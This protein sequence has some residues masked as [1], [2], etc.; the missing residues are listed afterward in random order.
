M[1]YI[2][3]IFTLLLV[4]GCAKTPDIFDK[5]WEKVQIKMKS[6]DKIEQSDREIMKEATEEEWKEVD[7]QS[8]TIIIPLKKPI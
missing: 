2:T 1:K 7:E 3:I 8:E 6:S 5:F 4:T